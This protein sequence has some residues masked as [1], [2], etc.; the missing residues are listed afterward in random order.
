MSQQ[1]VSGCVTD[2][3][4]L[5]VWDWL[6]Q[7]NCQ[8]VNAHLDAVTTLQVGGRHG[9][10]ALSNTEPLR[11]S[12]ISPAHFITFYHILIFSFHAST[13][14][15]NLETA[16]LRT[17]KTFKALS[18]LMRLLLLLLQPF[19]YYTAE[20][21]SHYLLYNIMNNAIIIII[22]LKRVLPM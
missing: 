22:M 11:S 20:S 13:P 19:A 17:S 2:A 8:S 4:K 14:K 10:S 6:S 21:E 9:N 3:G 7:E 15:P 16:L 18:C 1:P 12:G 5:Q